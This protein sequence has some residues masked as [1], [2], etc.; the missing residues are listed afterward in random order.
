MIVINSIYITLIPS[1]DHI[2][3]QLYFLET[4]KLHPTSFVFPPVSPPPDTW[5]AFLLF[6]GYT[7][8]SLLLCCTTLLMLHS[9]HFSTLS[10]CCPDGVTSHRH[11]LA[12]QTKT[13][14]HRLNLGITYT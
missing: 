8:Q 13:H 6:P 2:H 7:Y 10:I 11:V 4:V 12:T 14:I 5:S 9:P 3:I 1:R